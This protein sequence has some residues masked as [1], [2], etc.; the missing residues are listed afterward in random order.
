MSRTP[1][2]TATQLLAVAAISDVAHATILSQSAAVRGS[3]DKGSDYQTQELQAGGALIVPFDGELG[4]EFRQANAH[5][6][7]RD[8]DPNVAATSNTP[9]LRNHP[10]LGQGPTMMTNAAPAAATSKTQAMPPALSAIGDMDAGLLGMMTGAPQQRRVKSGKNSKKNPP[11]PMQVTS[12]T[13]APILIPPLKPT[14]PPTSLPVDPPTDFPTE[15]PADEPTDEPTEEP[16]TLSPTV[17]VGEDC[18]VECTSRPVITES[19]NDFRTKVSNCI[20]GYDGVD[21]KECPDDVPIGCWDT[22]EV[23]DMAY[24]FKFKRAFNDSIKC[25][26]VER[27][28][29]MSL[30][31]YSATDFN[32]PLNNWNVASVT[33]MAYMFYDAPKFNQCLSSW[34]DK[35]P[36]DVEVNDIFTD[37]G[38]PNRRP[39]ATVGPWCQGED[40]LCL[41]P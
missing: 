32:Q 14:D 37:S 27:V 29:D 28:T 9:V 38:C 23:T 40:L 20:G 15:K 7:H 26:N 24:G 5:H 16:S 11:T 33:D 17:S 25:W 39:V 1:L 4:V 2:T 6:H 19:G 22:S 21:A 3:N 10:S 35:T 13:L 41:L 8:S 36:P 18:K 31:F 30:M 12:P 34:A